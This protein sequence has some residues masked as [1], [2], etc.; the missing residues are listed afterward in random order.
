M[1]Q[2]YTWDEAK[3]QANLEKHGL[4]FIDADLVLGSRIKLELDSPRGSE[5]RKQVFAYVTEVLMTLTV[6]YQPLFV[7]RI[8]SFRPAKRTER[9]AYY[10]WLEHDA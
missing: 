8:I 2:V 5:A 6:V 9:E 10:E 3:R 1:Q 4:D 7:P